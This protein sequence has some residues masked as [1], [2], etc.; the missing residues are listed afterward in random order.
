ME[1][2]DLGVS[3]KTVEAL[4]KMG[5]REA[6]P[7]QEKVI[8]LLLKGRNVGA[9]AKTGSGKTLAYAVPVAEAIR[10]QG[11]AQVLVLAPT[12]E[13]ALQN[14]EVIKKVAPW[15]KFAII[16]GGVGYEPQFRQLEDADVVI[17]TPGRLLDHM[18]RGSLKLKT[19]CMVVLDEAD[20]M[21]DMGF[22]DDVERLI[23]STNRDR[24]VWLFSATL[25]SDIMR[26]A[27]K[28]GVNEFIE[29][30]EDMPA[31]IDHFFI[32]Y[33]NKFNNLRRLLEKNRKM[34]VFSNTKRMARM[35]SQRMRLPAI[36][37]DLSQNAREQALRKF[38]NGGMVLVATDVAARGLDIPNVDMVVNFDVPK[39]SKTYVHRI[40]RTGRAG[41]PGVVVNLLR[42]EDY[43]VFGKMT[44][45]L[46]LEVS[47]WE[48]W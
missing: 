21:L 32:D 37:G 15:L 23:A 3:P 2:K 16:Y 33:D 28:F 19:A 9:K 42:N 10:R 30:G 43:E 6:F 38:S 39:D 46:N 26:L 40:G 47:R 17:G 31:Q 12:R 29:V 8:P 7:I 35:L 13:L 41:K 48:N 36:S 24:R 4:N 1:F 25:S 5:I 44:G 18:Q 34:L 20:R 45:E 11:H 27:R 22:R 14:Y